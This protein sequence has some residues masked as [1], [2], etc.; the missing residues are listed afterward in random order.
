VRCRR[1]RNGRFAVAEDGAVQLLKAGFNFTHAS[2]SWL[3][4]LPTVLAEQLKDLA[5]V[6]HVALVAAA[7]AMHRRSEDRLTRDALAFACESDDIHDMTMGRAR[8]TGQVHG[9]S[10]G[11]E[12]HD[13]S[14]RR[15]DS[16]D[17]PKLIVLAVFIR[18]AIVGRMWFRCCVTIVL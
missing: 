6:S 3:A 12:V 17:R 15:V 10:C 14:C 18:T 5:N 7:Y 13:I 9:R 4:T 2:E 11:E 16:A 1:S 8:N